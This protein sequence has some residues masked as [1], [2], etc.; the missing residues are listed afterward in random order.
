MTKPTANVGP[1]VIIGAQW[2]AEL[3]SVRA[4]YKSLADK[5]KAELMELHP[6]YHY[7]PRK[8]GEKKRRNRKRALSDSGDVSGSLHSGR[9]ITLPSFSTKGFDELR[10]QEKRFTAGVS[11]SCGGKTTADVSPSLA[12]ARDADFSMFLD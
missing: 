11:K 12:A 4:H 9:T 7:C 3:P 10:E 2:R 8:P 5:V 1:A 6:D